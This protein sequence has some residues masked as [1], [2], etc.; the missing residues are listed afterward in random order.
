MTFRSAA[1]RFLLFTA[2]AIVTLVTLNILPAFPFA[3]FGSIKQIEIALPKDANF[4]NIRDYG[5]KGNGTSDDTEAIRQAVKTNFNSDRTILFPAGTY[6]VSDTIAWGDK[7]RQSSLTWQGEGFG[8]TIIKL[9]DNSKAFSNSQQPHSLIEINDKETAS[10]RAK[11]V[12]KNYLFDLSLNI[13]KNNPGA[14]G[15]NFNNSENGAIENVAIV[16]EDKKGAVGL[17]LGNNFASGLVKNLTIKGFD[18]AISGGT[19]TNSITLE[20]LLLEKQNRVGIE[21]KYLSLAIRRL[22]SINSVPAVSNSGGKNSSIVLIDSELRGGDRNKVAIENNGQ[23]FI[24]NVTIQGYQT[25]IALGNSPREQISKKLKEVTSTKITEYVSSAPL[26]VFDPPKLK[27]PP[28]SLNVYIEETPKFIDRNLHNWA[29]VVN[30][31]AKPNDGIDDS[32]AIQKAIDSGKNTVYFPWGTY[33]LQTSAIVRGKVRRMLGFNSTVRS[34]SSAFIFANKEYPILLE[35]FNFTENSQLEHRS[36]QTVILRHTYVPKVKNIVA[37]SLLLL[38]N[39]TTGAIALSKE[40]QLYA[41]QLNSKLSNS[42]PSIE[43]N[44]GIVW[45]FGYYSNLA[46]TAAASFNGALTEIYAGL[47]STN[48]PDNST[49]MPLLINK[50]ASMSAVYR[51][52]SLDSPFQIQI[53]ETHRQQTKI[54]TRKSLADREKFVMPL[55]IGYEYKNF[56]KKNK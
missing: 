30:Y 21:N 17:Y 55:Y 49:N 15:I 9:K 45:L 20:N 35:R 11:A 50:E 2:I 48:Y 12:G 3:S 54:L 26:A 8:K 25:S 43:N 7:N 52:L 42:N 37:K 27:T 51:E 47:F 19:T 31:G 38:E 13:G 4:I 16:S 28:K 29:N 41:H 33:D 39:V 5:A 23:I 36:L 56:Y 44:N 14:I 22:L 1:D 53:Q 18:V 32:V 46:N 10:D 40:Q 34:N 24:R 6:L